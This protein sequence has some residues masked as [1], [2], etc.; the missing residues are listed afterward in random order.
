LALLKTAKWRLPYSRRRLLQANLRRLTDAQSFALLD[1]SMTI[2]NGVGVTVHSLR[3]SICSGIWRHCPAV[4]VVSAFIGLF[5]A[6]TLGDCSTGGNVG[7]YIIDPGHYSAYHCKELADRLKELL[8][9]ENEL[10]N[11]TDKAS[12]GGGGTVIGALAYRTDYEKA[13]GEEKVLR[14]TATEKKC[15]LGP[16]AF[17]SDQVI[18]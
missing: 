2:S 7:P 18:R 4:P 17:E 5:L 14:R 12:E 1:A 16:P 10:R 11:L 9:R 15:E 6:G 8:K 3:R 13:Q